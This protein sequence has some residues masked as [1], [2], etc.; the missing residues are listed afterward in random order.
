MPDQISRRELADLHSEEVQEIIGR[1]PNG[2][3]RWG[4]S[5]FFFVLVIFLVV[6]WMIKYSDTVNGSLVLSAFNSPKTVV[7]NTSGKLVRLFAREGKNADKDEILGY[8]ESTAIHEEVLQLSGVINEIWDAVRKDQ[9]ASISILP[10]KYMHLGELQGAFQSFYSNYIQVN[11]FL[12]KDI[13]K[14]KKLLLKQE[15]RNNDSLKSILNRQQEIHEKDFA[16]AEND[17]KVQNILF[18][19]SVIAMFE[20]KQEESKL[21]NKK[22]PLE[23]LKASIIN[24]NSTSIAI[25]KELLE[26]EKQFMELKYGFLQALNSLSNDLE[27]WKK[28]F[29]LVS[30]VKGTVML[31]GIIQENQDLTVGQEVFYIAPE[32]NRFYGQLLLEQTNF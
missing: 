26:L 25:E 21:L 15:M 10:E 12:S 27:S 11:T 30:P 23:N 13:Y 24:N 7:A 1:A 17:Y 32:N 31:S 4:I 22:L 3:I 9:W 8:I 6:S 28:Q 2:L 16:I 14:T 20:L 18:R 29:L 5:S 19:D